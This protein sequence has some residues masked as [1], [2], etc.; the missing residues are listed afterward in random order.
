MT[1][2]ERFLNSMQFKPVDRPARMD[3]FL[4]TEE[5]F[6][7]AFPSE[8]TL[9]QS[10]GIT[11]SE[12]IEQCARLEVKIAEHFDHDAIFAW[13]PFAGEVTLEV[14]AR[15]RQLIGDKKAIVGLVP[16][17]F[18]GMEQI[19][20]HMEFAARLADDMA[21]LHEEARR[22]QEDAIRRVH[23]LAR[24]GA[25]AAYIPNDQGFNTGPYFSPAIYEELVLPY[26]QKIFSEIRRAGLIGIYHSD[27]N[28]MSLLDMIAATG[29]HG[30]QSI[31]PMAGMDIKEVKKRTYGKL[32]LLG[33]VQCSLL[34]EG[35]EEAIRASARYCLE[36]GS[37]NSGYVF[38]ASNSIFAG[39]PLANYRIMQNTYMEFVEIKGNKG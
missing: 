14:I 31:D 32:A 38:M 35:P 37:P 8:E 29:A 10:T 33:N 28:I 11:C 20:D 27:G 25:D 9:S 21:G 23:V 5:A 18:W 13:H 7:E 39:M 15:E 17:A 30:L 34:Q 4:L 24:A 22:M 3:A 16:N 1:G 6:G 12:L 19:H 2:R 26:A 36:H